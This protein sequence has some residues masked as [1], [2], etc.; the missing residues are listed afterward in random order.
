MSGSLPHAISSHTMMNNPSSGYSA[1]DQR[2]DDSNDQTSLNAV[3]AKASSDFVIRLSEQGQALS[4]NR[5]K[6]SDRV[7]EKASDDKEQQKEGATKKALDQD[8][9]LTPE[10]EKQVEELKRRDQ[11][12]RVHE[13]AHAS[14]GGVKTGSPFYTYTQGPDGKRYITDGE[15]SIIVNPTSDD[16][17]KTIS[18]MEQVYRAAL[19]PA[20]PSSADRKAAAEAQAIIQ[21]ARQQLAKQQQ[22]K[23]STPNSHLADSNVNNTRNQ[24]DATEVS[25]ALSSQIDTTSS[26]QNS[27]SNA[28]KDGISR[29][30]DFL[31]QIV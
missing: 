4:Q 14:V 27:R 18:D 10:E 9:D 31:N 12:V 2:H 5:D 28:Y 1:F 8:N 30:G 17:E 13:Q 3:N 26:V 19:A 24:T 15:V 7:N 6:E 29:R 22:E 11:E 20:E 16:P 23:L 25:Q 21:Q